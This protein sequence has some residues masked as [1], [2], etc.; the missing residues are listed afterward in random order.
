[1]ANLRDGSHLTLP[2][3]LKSNYDGPQGDHWPHRSRACCV[4]HL[5]VFD[6]ALILRRFGAGRNYT[7]KSSGT[8]V[9]PSRWPER[10]CSR[11]SRD[12]VSCW[13]S[14]SI[15]SFVNGEKFLVIVVLCSSMER[16]GMPTTAV[17]TGKL[18]E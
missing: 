11:P 14:R 13:R 6:L 10:R 9:G 2:H 1:M 16:V 17:V 18:M 12:G 8:A 4:F 5:P 15:S 7:Q 3:F